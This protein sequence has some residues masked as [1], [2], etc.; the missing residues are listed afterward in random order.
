M[1]PVPQL[2]VDYFDVAPVSLW[3]ADYSALKT[4]FDQWRAQGL[5]DLPAFLRDHPDWTVRCW[6]MVKL[7]RVNRRTLELFGTVNMQE[8]LAHERVV[9]HSGDPVEATYPLVQLWNLAPGQHTFQTESVNHS[10]DGRR[11]DARIN[12]TLLPGYEHN[13]GQVLYSIEDVSALRA[14]EEQ[15]RQIASQIPGMVYRVHVDREGRRTYLFVS[16]G[17][18]ELYGV[19]P[20]QVLA[21]GGLLRSMRHPEDRDRTERSLQEVVQQDL[22]LTWEFRILLPDGTLKWVQMTSAVLTTDETGSTR[23][24]V[25]LD[26]TARKL[27]EAQLR[28]SEE[29]WKLALAST[30]DGV[31]EWDARTGSRLFAPTNKERFGYSEEEF[32][33]LG[34]RLEELIHPDDLAQRR[35]DRLAHMEGRAETYANEHRLLCKDGSWRWVQSRGMAV[36]HDAQSKPLRV[37]GTYTDISER[38][39]AEALIW[40]QA[41]FDTLT[42]LPNRRMLRDRMEQEIRKGRRGGSHMA[43]LF[44]D[45]DHFKEVNDTLGH[46]SGDQLLVLAA[47]RIRDCLRASDT[48]ARMGGDEFTVLVPDLADGA[49]LERLLHNIL[50]TLST[51]FQLGDEQV[52]VSASIGIT[53][54]P[55]DASEVE[56]LLKNADQALYAAKGAGRNRFSFFTP[57][58]QEAAQQRARLS[59]DLR[60]ALAADQLRVYYQPI[61]ELASG[62]MHKAEALLRWQHPTRGFVSPAEFIPIA[63]STG[64]IGDMGEW[65]FRQVA[66]QVRHLRATHDASFQISMNRSPVEFHSATTPGTTWT[67]R[68][69]ALGLPGSAIAVEIT[70]GLLLEA[71][72]NVTEQLL[73][74]RD[75][76]VQISLDDFGT[77]YSSLSYLQRYDIDFIKIDQSFV[78]HLIPASTDLALCKAIIRMA[79]EL[80]MKVVAEGV[81]TAAQRDLLADAG[82]DYGQGYFFA[83]PMPAEA[84]EVHIAALGRAAPTVV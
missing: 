83:R 26:I 40:Q 3:L 46:D 43:L 51:S 76:G 10:L 14:S 57:A 68:L 41:N 81:E 77:G 20:Q 56:S 19:T 47:H 27:A 16:E 48:V 28:E 69:Q 58:L 17:V 54:Y 65:V 67:Q 71:G 32:A 84:L 31:W 30:A 15:F 59:H 78:R 50:R 1:T 24:G 11:V 70:E 38:K 75:C 13:W 53:M 12:A 61:V 36:S 62:A 82:C 23:S 8:L 25:M 2:P 22:P 73:E 64:L 79:H 80:G 44:I 29:R 60:N 34:N 72:A 9:L 4:Q 74:M 35:R 49:Q 37:V 55:Q 52:F 5:T 42:G 18:R 39:R 45:L 33:Q 6:E 21:D 7:L 66:H 63:E